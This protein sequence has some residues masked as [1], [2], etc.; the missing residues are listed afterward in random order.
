MKIIEFR[1]LCDREWCS[2]LHGYGDVVEL[3][4]TFTSYVDL[5]QDVM[6]ELVMFGKAPE[7]AKRIAGS[8]V[9]TTL[10]NPITRSEVTVRSGATMDE[11]VVNFGSHRELLVISA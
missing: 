11:A 2:S 10:V 6:A 3:H 5:M 4:L 9:I 1:E 8:A 7:P